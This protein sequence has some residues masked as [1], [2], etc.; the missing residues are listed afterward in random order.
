MF[1]ARIARP[2]VT[3]AALVGTLVL[4]AAPAATAGGKPKTTGRGAA[5]CAPAGVGTGLSPCP[6]ASA[7][8]CSASARWAARYEAAGL[9]CV[10]RELRRAPRR[11]TGRPRP[12]DP[13]PEPT[14]V[15][16]QPQPTP[17][18]EPTPVAPDPGPTPEPAPLSSGPFT[19]VLHRSG[20]VWSGDDRTGAA[21]RVS[22]AFG[23]HVYGNPALSPDETTV[24]Y[25]RDGHEL[26]IDGLAG[27]SPTLLLRPT[28][29]AQDAWQPSF[30]PSG[31]RVLFTQAGDLFT[32]GTDGTGL[33]AVTATTEENEQD[34]AFSP[35]GRTIAFSDRGRLGLMA[36]DGTDV[37]YLTAAFDWSSW[38]PRWSPDGTKLV[39][40]AFTATGSDVFEV[41][42]DG[43]GL[44][45]V[46]ASARDEQLPDYAPDGAS[47]LFDRDD[48]GDFAFGLWHAGTDGSGATE[49]V[50]QSAFSGAYR[51]PSTLPR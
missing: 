34:G 14:P 45:N 39:F 12:A 2:L 44:R 16:P 30:H 41:R 4:I 24:V 20:E 1:C 22:P 23:E 10:G 5:L 6:G 42:A 49:L 40:Y 35:D 9:R 19:I 21:V 38:G 7:F 43:T 32:V 11:P 15:A 36:A 25:D 3:T 46:T 28:D 17:Q 47:L 18:P 48:D 37:R 51:Q 29:P 26:W 31:D 8:R 13:L 50:A 27:G 33:T